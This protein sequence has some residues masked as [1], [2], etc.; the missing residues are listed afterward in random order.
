MKKYF[1]AFCVLAL[2]A[3]CAKENIAP[4]Q[5]S[6]DEVLLISYAGQPLTKTTISGDKTD[7][8]TANWAEKDAIGV[9]TTSGTANAEHSIAIQS[10]GTAKFTGNVTAS[11]N[12]QT[13]YAYYPYSEAAT[14]DY[15]AVVLTLPTEQFMEAGTYDAAAAIMVG[16]PQT[17]TI[18]GESAEIGDWQ[19]AHLNSYI[20][21]STKDITAEGVSAEER[22]SK[23]TLK[24]AGKKLA[25][26]FKLNLEDGQ[27]TFTKAS[28][29]VTVDVPSGTT[30]GNLAAWV[31]TAPF[32]LAN[33]ELL[34]KIETEAHIVAKSVTL[35]KEFKAGNVYTLGVN[36]ESYFIIEDSGNLT[37]NI[38]GEEK[39]Y[40][41]YSNTDWEVESDNE[42]FTVTKVD[43][44]TLKVKTA[45]NTSFLPKT[46]KVTLSGTGNSKTLD[47]TQKT[48]WKAGRGNCVFNEDGSV[49]I[50]ADETEKSP[51]IM[52][53][54]KSLP[55]TV[56]FGKFVFKVREANLS[57]GYLHIDTKGHGNN[58]IFYNIQIGGNNKLTCSGTWNWAAPFFTENGEKKADDNSNKIEYSIEEIN[59]IENITFQIKPYNRENIGFWLWIDDNKVIDHWGVGNPWAENATNWNWGVD[60]Y[61]G[62][63]DAAGSITLE[64]CDFTQ[65]NRI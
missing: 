1:S 27:V 7:G 32:S 58:S 50:T 62:I 20:Q 24:A 52:V 26:D 18:D 43:A 42:A 39:T 61:V 63:S 46:A 45:K 10:D 38:H 48:L 23:V 29:E 41:V 51:R 6:T 65:F 35:T 8:F 33:E 54:I 2:A 25:G 64:S 59:K 31:V 21:I 22:V 53:D 60:F 37:F 49:T 9:Y 28:A 4:V 36:V 44:N 57:E 30:L 34:I 56:D 13:L 15:K 55:N 11:E 19:F 12:E 16:K 14:G 3:G 47:L 40:N 5:T 17:A